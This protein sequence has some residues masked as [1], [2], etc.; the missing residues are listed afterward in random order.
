MGGCGPYFHPP[1]VLGPTDSPQTYIVIT[2][3]AFPYHRPGQ[4]LEREGI[5][6]HHADVMK[7]KDVVRFLSTLKLHT[8]VCIPG[9]CGARDKIRY[10][11]LLPA[12]QM[13]PF[14]GLVT[15]SFPDAIK[16]KGNI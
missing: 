1:P 6:L 12:G 13:A 3:C 14:F 2:F 10:S 7:T 16:Q 15:S 11:G 4:A 8:M 5:I 9:I